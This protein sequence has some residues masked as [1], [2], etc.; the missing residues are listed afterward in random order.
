MC[1]KIVWTGII[2]IMKLKKIFKLLA[3]NLLAIFV[4]F[5]ICH[6]QD[7]LSRLEYAYKNINDAS[8]SFTQTSYIKELN[9]TQLFKGKFFIKGDKVRWQYSGEFPQVIYLNKKTLIIYDKKKKQAIQSEFNEEKYGQ[10]PLALLGR[11]ANLKKDFEITEKSENTIV[12]IP[13]SRMGN[14][15]SIELVIQEGDFP[16]KSMKL[17]DTMANVVKIDF[18]DVKINTSLKDSIFKFTPKKDDT[19]LKL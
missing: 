18:S 7:L 15:K 6:A 8:G 17:T 14:I 2:K 12:L 10:L 5:N 3:S 11:M 19:V 1:Q 13:K 16:V 9:K 4:F